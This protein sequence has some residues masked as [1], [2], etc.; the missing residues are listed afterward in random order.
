MNTVTVQESDDRFVVRCPGED[1]QVVGV[2]KDVHTAAA[3]SQA[4][5]HGRY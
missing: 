5:S 2:F 1:G 4:Y 3:F